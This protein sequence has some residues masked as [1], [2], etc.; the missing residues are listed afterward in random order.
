[1]KINAGRQMR[2]FSLALMWPIF[3]CAHHFQFDQ[4]SAQSLDKSYQQGFLL[5]AEVLPRAEEAFPS[6]AS[7]KASVSTNKATRVVAFA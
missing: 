2:E 7:L 6:A 3:H 4:D 5:P 1:M